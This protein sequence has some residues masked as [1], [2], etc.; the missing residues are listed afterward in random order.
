MLSHS[1]GAGQCELT[2]LFVVPL[3]LNDLLQIHAASQGQ[4]KLKFVTG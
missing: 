2:K 1:S 4:L 3:N